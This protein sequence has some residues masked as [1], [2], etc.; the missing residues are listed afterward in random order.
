MYMFDKLIGFSMLV[1]G[2]ISM[3]E[4]ITVINKIQMLVIH[5]EI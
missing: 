3:V 4:A 5:R 2:L 1:L